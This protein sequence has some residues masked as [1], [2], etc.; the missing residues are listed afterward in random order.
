MNY[1]E[2]N[3]TFTERTIQQSLN[4]IKYYSELRKTDSIR[5]IGKQLIR[6]ST[7][8]GANFRAACVARSAKEKFA[9]YCIVVE[10]ADEV[11]YWLN[12]LNR[13]HEKLMVPERILL[14][15]KEIIKVMTACKR[16]IGRT[17]GSHK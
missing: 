3:Q 16:G 6:C 7:S 8:V 5:I 1:R 14:E 13:H 15:A 17:I 11:V 4:I 2:F 12:L 9:K 10:E